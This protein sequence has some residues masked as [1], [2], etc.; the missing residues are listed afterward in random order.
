MWSAADAR[1]ARK[2]LLTYHR[3]VGVG[4]YW[5]MAG[6]GVDPRYN[7]TAAEATAW[8]RAQ[9]IEAITLLLDGEFIVNGLRRLVPERR[10]ADA[11]HLGRLVYNI[12]GRYIAGSLL[13][14]ILAA[15]DAN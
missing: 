3:G 5:F 6:P 14:A 1:D 12:I 15:L 4:V 2:D 8:G 13:V 9:A 10:R 7:G 11:D